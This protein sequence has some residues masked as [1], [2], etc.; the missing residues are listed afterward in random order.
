MHFS[1][2]WLLLPLLLD[3][4]EQ[5]DGPSTDLRWREMLDYVLSTVSRNFSRPQKK[6]LGFQVYLYCLQS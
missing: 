4:P 5:K 3:D 2:H 6:N 1:V